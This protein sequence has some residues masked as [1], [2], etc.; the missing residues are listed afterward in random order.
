M[1]NIII[2]NNTLKVYNYEGIFYAETKATLM[3]LCASE[4]LRFFEAELENEKICY[5]RME[6]RIILNKNYHK[7][8]KEVF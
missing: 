5:A 2:G 4:T 8:T 3:K 7:F 1:N 6:D